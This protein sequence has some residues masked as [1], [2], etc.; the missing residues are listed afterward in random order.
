MQSAYLM[1]PTGAPNLATACFPAPHAPQ[2][3]SLP[4]RSDSR[5][6]VPMTCIAN[7]LQGGVE[8]SECATEVS[9]APNS[10][11]AG[12]GLAPAPDMP[13]LSQAWCRLPGEEHRNGGG[14]ARD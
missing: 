13:R 2:V 10:G 11:K 1:L 3:G 5:L 8:P 12:K 4:L 14:V 9:G 6:R 7:I